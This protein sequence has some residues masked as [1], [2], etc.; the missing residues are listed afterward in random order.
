M[1]VLLAAVFIMKSSKSAIKVT[2]RLSSF[3]QVIREYLVVLETPRGGRTMAFIFFNGAFHGGIFAW[4]GLLLISRYHLH[5]T[6]IGLAFAGY[7][8]PGIFFGTVIGKW[9]DR[10]GRSYVVPAGFLWS[11]GCAF[12][13]LLPSPRLVAALLI[14]A[15]SA[16]FDATHPLMSQYYDVIGPQTQ[17]SDYWTRDVHQLRRHGHRSLLLPATDRFPL[18]HCASHLRLSTDPF[19]LRSPLWLSRRAPRPRAT[20]AAWRACLSVGNQHFAGRMEKQPAW[21]LLP[22]LKILF[23]SAISASFTPGVSLRPSARENMIDCVLQRERLSGALRNANDALQHAHSL[24]RSHPLPGEGKKKWK[25]HKHHGGA[26]R[27]ALRPAQKARLFSATRC[28]R[29]RRR[30]GRGGEREGLS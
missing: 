24:L 12:L 10:Y 1:R 23:S 26:R 19:R 4:L 9:G 20:H 5:D 22:D 29:P 6:G 14:T 3:E 11:A 25:A 2:R 16:G 13:L 8:L 21:R 27:T 15:L 18:Y 30:S 28:T 7:G 17:R